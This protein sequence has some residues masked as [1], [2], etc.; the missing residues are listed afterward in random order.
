MTEIGKICAAIVL[1][2]L[3][4]FALGARYGIRYTVE[5][6]KITPDGYGNVY[7]EIDGERHLY[8]VDN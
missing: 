3:F 8:I 6:Q 2:G 1:L 4:A 7:A 5:T